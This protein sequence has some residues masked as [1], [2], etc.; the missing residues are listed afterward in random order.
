MYGIV[1]MSLIHRV[2]FVIFI[3]MNS[4]NNMDMIILVNNQLCIINLL[5][6]NLINKLIINNKIQQVNSNFLL[7]MIMFHHLNFKILK[8]KIINYLLKRKTIIIINFLKF[9]KFHF[10]EILKKMKLNLNQMFNQ[11]LI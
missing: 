4:N 7:V 2:K 11:K 5:Y 10:K 8:Y 3:I 6:S 1:D 9:I